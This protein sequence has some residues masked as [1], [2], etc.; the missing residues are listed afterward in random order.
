[1][2]CSPLKLGDAFSNFGRSSRAAAAEQVEMQAAIC[3]V[4]EIANFVFRKFFM[5]QLDRGSP[6]GQHLGSPEGKIK[7]RDIALRTQSVR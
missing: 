2:P 1:M 5:E 3:D 6:E 7:P 4:P